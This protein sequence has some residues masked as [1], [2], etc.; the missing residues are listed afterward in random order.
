[1]LFC[2]N[3]YP[4]AGWEFAQG[5]DNIVTMQLV[6]VTKNI[7]SPIGRSVDIITEID[8]NYHDTI[9]HD[10]ELIPCTRYRKEIK[11]IAQGD[12]LK[13]IY[14]NGDYEILTETAPIKVSCESGSL[15]VT[16]IPKAFWEK[17]FRC[18]LESWS[19]LGKKG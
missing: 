9:I 4:L 15:K 2:V 12:G 14:A 10:I 17:N 7:E 1:M 13:I 5:V 16:V 19:G 3:C 18:C 6:R 8:T 11:D